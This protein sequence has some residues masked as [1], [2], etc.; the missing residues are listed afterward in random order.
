MTPQLDISIEGH[1]GSIVLNRPEAINA[2]NREMIDAI[3]TT[4]T[5]WRDDPEVRLVLFEGRGPRGFC[6]GGDVRA[7]RALVL[8]GRASEAD[9]YF[10]AEYAMNG[11]IASYPKPTTAIGHGAVMGG[12]IGIFGHCHYRFAAAEAR[13][14]MPEAAIGFVSDVGVNALLAQAPEPR[15]LAFLMAGLPISVGDALVLGLCDVAV[16]RDRLEAVRAGIV[17]AAGSDE[18]EASLVQLMALEGVE[19]GAAALAAA[20]DRLAAA[21]GEPTAS[22][23][24][25]AVRATATTVPAVERLAAALAGR[26]PTSLEAIVQSHRAARRD[27]DIAAVL[28]LDTRLAAFM[29]RR[30][31]FAEG[32]RAVLVDKDH[33][34]HWRPAAF[35]DVDGGAIAAVVAGR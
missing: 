9:A 15:A 18:I 35:A 22:A 3:A 2:L 25:A 23:I 29:A 17:A 27:P 30:P 31:D 11:L 13:F 1:L 5:R 8:D 24:V 28:A 34:A 19:P 16:A 32:V 12:G 14:A 33:Q 21:F 26:S 7:A 10:A 4:L 6:S 20:G